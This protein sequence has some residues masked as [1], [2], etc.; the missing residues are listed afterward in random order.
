[1]DQRA[2]PGNQ[3]KTSNMLKISLKNT[4]RNSLKRLVTLPRALKG[5][6]CCKL[7][8]DPRFNSDFPQFFPKTICTG[9]QSHD[10][11]TYPCQ[12]ATLSQR[13]DPGVSTI[14]VLS[15]LISRFHSCWAIVSHTFLRLLLLWSDFYIVRFP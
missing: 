4:T 8:Q 6:Q 14:I 11:S 1:M 15:I 9:F 5:G 12:V 2:T 3:R 7:H 10:P 13:Q